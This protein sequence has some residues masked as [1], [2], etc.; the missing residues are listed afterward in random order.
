VDFG[1]VATTG[2]FRLRYAP[3]TE[4][5][6]MPLPDSESFQVQLRLDQLGA[7]AAKVREMV[8]QDLDGHPLAPVAPEQDGP[9]VRWKTDS[10][11]FRYLIRF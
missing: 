7:P 11:A 8:A 4:W 1:P 10:R 3:N 9:L 5:E 2:A 6:L